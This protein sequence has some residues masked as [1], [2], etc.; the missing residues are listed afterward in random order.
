MAPGA[1]CR[2]RRNTSCPERL[3]RRARP[4]RSRFERTVVNTRGSLCH[5][6]V[7]LAD[8]VLVVPQGSDPRVATCRGKLQNKRSRLNQEI[9]KE[10]RLRA[11]AENLF[12]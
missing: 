4:L 5:G 10:L 3:V 8:K 1:R 6:V 12:K 2:N 11:G 9:N 7:V